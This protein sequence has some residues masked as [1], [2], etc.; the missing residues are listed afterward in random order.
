MSS[1]NSQQGEKLANTRTN[2]MKTLHS[3]LHGL[4][5]DSLVVARRIAFSLLFLGAGLALVEPC[6]CAPIVFE[7]TGALVGA[8]SN[9]RATVLAN[10]KVLVVG[11]FDGS[12]VL[13]SAELYDPASGT[14]TATGSLATGRTDH[15]ATL[16]PNGKVLVA[17]GTD[18]SFKIVGS[19]ELY[20]PTSGTWT[21]VG[22]MTVA[23]SRHTATLLPNGKV[24]IAS[25][26]GTSGYLAS[27]E[28]YDPAT[29]IWTATSGL[30][31]ARQFHTATL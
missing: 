12:S 8:R 15:T 9:H 28:L 1:T 27:A 4:G 3:P 16:L 23:R 31:M 22:N 21:G 14:W 17:G 20:D 30:A 13:A 7:S 5:T 6:M 25:G 24:I 11:G 10:G 2:K 29:G 18:R 26:L 19:A